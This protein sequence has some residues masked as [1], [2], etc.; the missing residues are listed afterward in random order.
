MAGLITHTYIAY[1]ALNTFSGRSMFLK[2]ICDSQKELKNFAITG[3]SYEFDKF[4]SASTTYIGA[5]GPDLFYFERHE[6]GFFIADTMHYNKSGLYVI[7]LLKTIKK[8]HNVCQ[9]L[10]RNLSILPPKIIRKIAYC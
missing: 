6:K 5:C 4:L 1:K 10:K 8:A 7:H 2:A 9:K 3:D